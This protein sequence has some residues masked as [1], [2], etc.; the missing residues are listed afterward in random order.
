MTVDEDALIACAD[1]IGRTGATNFEI[2]YLH[3]DV[4]AE[5]A[6]WYA[7]AQFRGARI[8]EENH[9][10]PTEAAEALARRILTGAKCRCGKLVALADDG[11]IAFDGTL[12]DGSRFTVEEARNAGQCRWARVGARWEMG[13]K[14]RSSQQRSAF[15]RRQPKKT[16]R[17]RRRSAQRGD[18]DA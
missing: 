2:G 13:C 10:G 14:E 7:H 6:A 18:A 3:D 9:R 12:V 17:R 5:D 4:P 11:A 15:P 8:T 1:L 16:S